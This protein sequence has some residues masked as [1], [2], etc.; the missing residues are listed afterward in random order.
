M[1]VGTLK[2]SGLS[3]LFFFI[4]KD[5]ITMFRLIIQ[6]SLVLSFLLYC[7][8]VYAEQ[9]DFS[10]FLNSAGNE[11]S[12]VWHKAVESY[13][14]S[15]PKEI[16]LLGF[17]DTLSTSI[18]GGKVDIT[19]KEVRF[20]VGRAFGI[21]WRIQTDFIIENKSDL[22][23]TFSPGEY[24]RSANN[25]G[26]RRNRGGKVDLIEPDNLEI[27]GNSVKDVT[28]TWETRDSSEIYIA[29]NA[30]FGNQI[31]TA[32]NF[33]EFKEKTYLLPFA[34]KTKYQYS[35][36]VDTWNFDLNVTAPEPGL[37]TIHLPKTSTD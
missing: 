19:L 20:Y 35:N 33:T 10:S 13:K 5:L 36:D 21:F 14:E 7:P 17:G 32:S 25:S 3:F 9:I 24:F 23:L 12:N 30:D 27:P 18:E 37:F 8:N 22:S 26:Y 4:L 31:E 15:L 6:I 1:V 16:P 34:K 2:L 28:L 29:V 11:V